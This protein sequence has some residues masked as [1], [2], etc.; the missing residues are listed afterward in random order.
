M[1][2]GTSTA[3]CFNPLTR[4]RQKTGFAFCKNVSLY[5]NT[6]SEGS[7]SAIRLYSQSF[8]SP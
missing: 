4:K 2:A 1:K 6:R 3:D 7:A 8:Y 5:I